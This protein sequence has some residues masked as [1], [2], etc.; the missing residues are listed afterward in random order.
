MLENSD[1]KLILSLRLRIAR[2]AQK[3]SLKWW[4]DDSLTPSG[5]FLLERL[6]IIDADEAGYKLAIEAAKVRYHAAFGKENNDLHLFH[7]DQTGDIEHS[8][9]GISLSSLPVSLEPS[10][11]VDSLR[12]NLLEQIGSP[13]KYQVVGERSN[14]RL[15]IKLGDAHSKFELV[16]IVKTLA[17]ASLEG[18]PGKPVFPYIQQTS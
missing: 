4:E 17:W 9:Q 7:L 2:A 12:H 1:R 8:L 11:S 16:D 18:E 6:F 3:D 5:K 15:E 13:M 10:Q 14:N